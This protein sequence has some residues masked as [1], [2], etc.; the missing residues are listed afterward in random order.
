MRDAY[1]SRRD[2][3]RFRHGG[4]LRYTRA[5]ERHPAEE[6]AQTESPS[7][8]SGELLDDSALRRFASR[9]ASRIDARLRLGAAGVSAAGSVASAGAV[10]SSAVSSM[11][12]RC[13][14]T[15]LLTAYS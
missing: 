10:L 14:S 12:L 3:H 2:G 4:H 5:P 1:A 8:A 7:A 6:A 15:T 9:A 13:L 11:D